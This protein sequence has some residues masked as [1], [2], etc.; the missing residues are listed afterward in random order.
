MNDNV[1][2]VNALQTVDQMAMPATLED[3]GTMID[4]IIAAPVSAPEKMEKLRTVLISPE[5]KAAAE[6]VVQTYT[7]IAITDDTYMDA[8][9]DAKRLAGYYNKLEAGRKEIKK[10]AEAPIKAFDAALKEFGQIFLDGKAQIESVTVQYDESRK[11]ERKQ[12]I[13]KYLNEKLAKSYLRPEYAD[14]IVEPANAQNLSATLKSIKEAYDA[15]I[16]ALKLEQDNYDNLTIIANTMI[17]SENDRLSQ[18]LDINMFQNDIV[19]ILQ[20]PNMQPADMSNE[21]TQIIKER[22]N[23]LAEAE[24]RIR[25]QAIEAERARQAELAAQAATEPE[26]PAAPAETPAPVATPEPVQETPAETSPFAPPVQENVNPMPVSAIPVQQANIFEQNPFAAKPQ[27]QWAG[28]IRFTGSADALGVVIDA[29]Q[30]VCR[31][32]RV[33][34]E[35]LDS[36]QL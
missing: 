26:A 12:K 5:A 34:I 36:H 15:Q 16:E 20:T 23:S 33:S 11:E 7:S 29:L 3:L 10:E 25:Q 9:A 24:E 1:N 27:P 14:R 13:Q 31:E 18:K 19:R 35:I 2:N 30:T 22:A 21:I 6:A 17:N 28:T 8:K 4:G 32:N